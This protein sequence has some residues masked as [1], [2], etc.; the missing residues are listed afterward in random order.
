MKPLIKTLAA[1][2]ATLALCATAQA[3]NTYAAT[4]YPI[5]MAHG[6]F[7]FG[8]IG[9]VDYFYGISK[10]L[11][12]NGAKVYTTQ[13]DATNSSDVRGEQFVTQL[14]Q[15]LAVSGAQ[16]ANLIGHS[17]GAQT[18]RYA[19]GVMPGSVASVT[20]VS[21]VN[22]ASP[23]ADAINGFASYIGPKG[24]AFIGSLVSAFGSIESF[25][26]GG[27]LSQQDALG[28]LASMSTPGANAFNAR[29]PA[30]LPSANCGQGPAS[31]NGIR[32]YSW[33]GVAGGT[34]AFDPLDLLVAVTSLAFNGSPNDG[35]VG[36]CASHL[37]TVIRDDYPLNHFDTVNQAIGLHGSFDPVPLYR[38]HANRLKLQGL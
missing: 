35:L 14:K 37:G 36:K 3:A 9:P 30:G 32:F 16:K 28:A 29:F 7:G 12:S 21:G 20:T 22:Y 38:Q 24:T 17:Q 8:S 15:I 1:A 19:A 23:V 4:K 10:D 27:S 25:L 31:A 18:V 2:S 34:N 33:N 13:V 11:Q 5:V 26:A 6:L